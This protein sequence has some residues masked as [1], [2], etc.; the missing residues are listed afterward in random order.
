VS[1]QGTVVFFDAKAMDTNA[2]FSE[3]GTYVL[4]LVAYDGEF[5][6]SDK[7]TI[8]VTTLETTCVLDSQFQ[9]VILA[10]NIT[11]YTDRTY[12]LTNVP[13]KYI[14]MDMIK[15]PNDDRNLTAAS[16]Y[17]TFEMPYNGI[18][19]VALDSRVTSLPSWMGGFSNSGDRIYTSL[20][21]QPYL[22]VYKKSYSQ[23][24]CVNFGANKAPGFSGKFVSNYIVFW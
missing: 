6:S 8:T 21:S 11:Y 22:K 1:G 4:E 17:L 20:S 13:S 10:R 18:V 15:T 14:G 5:I 24:D 16:D 23:L 19:Y 12:K 2:N 7:V 9:Q 3:A